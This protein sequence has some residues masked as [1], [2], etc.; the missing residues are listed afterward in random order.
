MSPGNPCA[1]RSSVSVGEVHSEEHYKFKYEAY[2][3]KKNQNNVMLFVGVFLLPAI[4]LS[5]ANSEAKG[6]FFSSTLNLF[7]FIIVTSKY[8]L[9]HLH[10]Y[11][12][13]FWINSI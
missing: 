12:I 5:I 13:L 8:L 2:T 9:I 7:V 3:V 4:P 10:K 11:I 1:H 6:S